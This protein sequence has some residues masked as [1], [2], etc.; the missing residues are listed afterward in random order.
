MNRRAF[1]I[2]S[3]AAIGAMLAMSAYGLAVL[4]AGG[5][6]AIH[7]GLDGNPD[8]WAPRE[9]GL[10]V[11]PGVAGVL[12]ILLFVLPT[13]EPRRAHLARS[14]PA[15]QAMAVGVMLLLVLLHAAIV[16]IALGWTVSIPRV[17]ILG[18]GFV[19]VVIGNW[20][21]KLRSNYT[22][23]I[24]LPWTLSSERSWAVTHRLGGR[25]FVILGAGLAALAIADAP[26]VALFIALLGG[27]AILGAWLTVVAY[28]AWSVDPERLAAGS[29]DTSVR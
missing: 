7:W 26:P 20:L 11:T 23:G 25:G 2:A 28:R 18:A 9:V 22:A 17:A 6:I 29:R 5:P 4:P 27:M 14:G 13:V 8:G 15:Y 24:R 1:L 10:L 21:P 3:M 16:G 12:A 19:F